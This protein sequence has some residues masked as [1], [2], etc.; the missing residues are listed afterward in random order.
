[1]SLMP[2]HEY[3]KFPVMFETH[4]LSRFASRQEKRD[5]VSVYHYSHGSFKRHN[6]HHPCKLQCGKDSF[7]SFTWQVTWKDSLFEN[8]LLD[9]NR[10][11]GCLYNDFAVNLDETCILWLITALSIQRKRW[12]FRKHAKQ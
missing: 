6:D 11:I 8:F 4:T 10:R 1:M 5:Y 7:H 3:M 2:A 9:F 12:L